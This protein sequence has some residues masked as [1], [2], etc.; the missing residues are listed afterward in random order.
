MK[1]K[2]EELIF[3]NFLYL[4]LCKF[5]SKFTNDIY[6]I[7]T[8]SSIVES[9][10]NPLFN[11][12]KKRELIV[13]VNYDEQAIS[14]MEFYKTITNRGYLAYIIYPTMGCNFNCSYCYQDNNNE[15]MTDETIEAIIKHARKHI[16]SYRGIAVMW[17]GGEPLLKMDTFYKLSSELQRICHNQK[18]LYE[19]NVTTNGYFLTIDNFEKMLKLNTS[20]ISITID[21]LGKV[22]DAQRKLKNGKGSFDTIIKQLQQIKSISKNIDFYI[23]IRSNVS[24]EGYNDLNNYVKEMAKMFGE[25]KRY[26]FSFRPVYDWGGERVNDFRNSLINDNAN[27]NVYKRLLEIGIPLN[28]RQHYEELMNSSVCYACR[29]NFFAIETNGKISKCTSAEKN[30]KNFYVGELQ[31]NGNMVLDQELIAKWGSKYTKREA[32]KDCFLEANCSSNFCLVDK[33]AHDNES[34]KCPRVKYEIDY[35]ISLLDQSNEKYPYI[36]Y[37]NF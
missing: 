16:F 14:N 24:E 33:V 20:K 21:G 6:E 35:Y 23:N 32:C 22:H 18:R 36:E 11:E 7:I 12:L 25:D 5:D 15:S 19:A 29:N 10:G 34:I 37:I 31:K 9:D 27:K 4:Q 17:F 3:Y 13:P 1:N 8:Q 2:N 30:S 26:G 28:Y